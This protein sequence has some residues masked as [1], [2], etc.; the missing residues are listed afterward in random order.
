M[1][2]KDI[3]LEKVKQIQQCLKR[4]HEKTTDNP[5]TLD[6]FD[7]QDIF[8]LNLQRAVQ[9]CLDLATHIVADG[10]LGTPSELKENFILLEK[11]KVLTHDLSVK[12]QKMVGFRNIAV[13]D[14]SALDVEILKSILQNNLKDLEEFY[15]AILKRFSIVK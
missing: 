2:D 1:V 3:V 5:A 15:T 6:S 11:E 13:H 12:L 14:Y 9:S 7:I 8:V 10:A 4:I